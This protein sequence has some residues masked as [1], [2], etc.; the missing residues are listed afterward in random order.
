MLKSKEDQVKRE[1]CSQQGK[2]GS[3]MLAYHMGL[4]RMTCSVSLLQL[5]EGGQEG[6][7]GCKFN[8]RCPGPREMA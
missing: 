1:K 8:T 7:E 5:R 2:V 6:K 4:G 3:V